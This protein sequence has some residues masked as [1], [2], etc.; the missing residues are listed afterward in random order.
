MKY[1]FISHERVTN[2]SQPRGKQTYLSLCSFMEIRGREV[3][4]VGRKSR[5]RRSQHKLFVE[6]KTS[7][8]KLEKGETGGVG[9]ETRGRGVGGGN[10]RRG[11]GVWERTR[12]RGAKGGGDFFLRQDAVEC[13][14]VRWCFEF[15]IMKIVITIIIIKKN[16]KRT[17]TGSG[18]SP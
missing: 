10:S 2:A 4:C 5:D 13:V 1:F 15:I 12:E 9:Q 3:L 7:S 17:R 14:C 16:N 8:L 6:W 11:F 18:G